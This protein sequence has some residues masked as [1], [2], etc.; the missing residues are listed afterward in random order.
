MVKNKFDKKSTCGII[1]KMGTYCHKRDRWKYRVDF[2]PK[3]LMC[4]VVNVLNSLTI[5]FLMFSFICISI[6][7]IYKRFVKSPPN[8]LTQ[9]YML[10]GLP[11]VL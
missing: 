2:S 5:T 10:I 3:I 7:W 1:F 4:I 11:L 9:R 8:C 6:S